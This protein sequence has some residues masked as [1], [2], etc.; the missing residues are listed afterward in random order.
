MRQYKIYS[1]SA[2]ALAL[3]IASI[4]PASAA[5]IEGTV[6]SI[7]L[8][9]IKNARVEINTTP[10]QLYIARNSTYR[11]SVPVGNY[12]INATHR[13][14]SEESSIKEYVVVKDNGDYVLDLILFPESG[15]E[16]TEGQINIEKNPFSGSVGT[17]IFI[18]A[19]ILI[20]AVA[21]AFYILKFKAGK[22][23]IDNITPNHNKP[24]NDYMAEIL[25]IIEEE[26][27]RTTQKEIRKRIPY[28]EAKIS[29]MIAEL[30]GSGK[31]KKIKKG[32]GNIIILNKM[33]KM[34]KMK[35]K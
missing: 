32:R 3:L 27:G 7:S 22:S 18:I 26:G 16:L 8:E 23:K 9:E 19:G 15:E 5:R 10:R 1:V 25:K 21:A 17:L 30:E 29:L 24:D 34:G 6:Y 31:I 20:L 2:L 13:G 14:G 12:E 4:L 33:N 28:S 11:F 35:L